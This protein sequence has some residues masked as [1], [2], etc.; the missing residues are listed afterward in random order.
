MSN[1]TEQE[2]QNAVSQFVRE[3]VKLQRS[4]LG[5]LDTNNTFS[6]VLEYAA[7]TLVFNPSSIFYLISLA[8][9]RVN[10]DV[11]LAL[12]YLDDI[13]IGINEVGRD[14]VKVTRTSLLEDAAAALL[15]AERILTES[16]AITERQFSRYEAS[17]NKFT[18]ASLTPNIR[19]STGQ[20]FPNTYQISRPPQ[21]AQSAIKTS[22]ASLSTLHTTL[23][24]EVSQLRSTFSEFLALN[25][26]L[27]SIQGTVE[28]ARTDLRT[29]KREFDAA[30]TDDAI[31]MTRDAFL[32]IE[33]G[34]AVVLNLTSISDPTEARM[35][36][37]TSNTIRARVSSSPASGTAASIALTRSAPYEVIPGTQ[38]SIQLAVDGGGTQ[39]AT[40]IPA[41][42][43]FLVGTQGETFDI[44]ASSAANLTSVGVG[45]YTVPASPNNVFDVFVDGIGYR[46]TLTSGSRTAAQVAAKIDAATRID[47]SPGTF[48]A[49]ATASDSGGSLRLQ[50]DIA[51]EN[52][53][54]I[55]DQT[56]L[57]TA[58][59][60][61]SGQ[62]ST[63]Q[64]D[65]REIRFLVDDVV[66]V[67]ATLT[68]G[69][70]T[71]AQV[72]ADIAGASASIDASAI[73][74][75]AL[76]SNLEAVKVRS[77]SYGDGS[78]IAIKPITD[79]HRE[80]MET[81]GFLED[82]T[83]RSESTSLDTLHEAI[84]ALSGI[85]AEQSRETLQE[86]DGGETILDG[87]DY[88][89]RLAS[90]TIN[91]TPAS[92]DVIRIVGGSNVGHYR[93][94]A[95]SLG[96]TFDDVTVDRPFPI[97]TG[98]ESQ[99][100][101]WELLRD[102]LIISS[103]TISSSSSLEVVGGTLIAEVGLTAG[104]VRG[105]VSGVR[106]SSSGV[107]QSFSGNDVRIGDL[108]T[109]A[110][111][112]Y[113]TTHTVTDVTDGGYQI[114]VTPE[115]SNDMSAHLFSI[116]GSAYVE[117]REFEDQIS[118]W[119][120][121]VLGPSS[122]S[123]NILELERLLNPLL[124]NKNP[125][126]A[127]VSGART[128]AQNLQSIYEDLSTILE[129]FSVSA[130]TRID[131]LLDMLLERGL[132]RAHELLLL[133]QVSE[134]FSM[135]RDSASYSGNL[136]E[137]MREMAQ[138]DVPLGRGAE[139]GHTEERLLGSYEDTDFNWDFSDADAE[140]DIPEIDDTVLEEEEDDF[141]TKVY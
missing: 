100:Q 126:A 26:P 6:E 72:A 125:S 51:G 49:V 88:K 18:E 70:R 60:F 8:A 80:A 12:E 47:G 21:K 127:L 129:D 112:T 91:A 103:D 37:T 63:G 93:I 110:G 121:N 120:S 89:L 114:E 53:I 82:Q 35:E 109:L 2:V 14:T 79:V 31:G 38:D 74:V 135:T 52:T 95:V 62:S 130:V 24:S 108:L 113:S 17:L 134:F 1:F 124:V 33:A 68:T 75:E 19:E 27:L 50:H 85:T 105:T 48:S 56:T 78:S 73:T 59:G 29:L 20:P 42:P 41:D 97:V 67:A 46:A 111:P 123:E 71:A 107:D 138:N 117:Y 36:G 94:T 13:L 16:S 66:V 4:Q 140:L 90:G 137:K 136:L 5:P 106:V 92:G 128:A 102:V 76:P 133:G 30:T 104:T 99:N 57:N 3:G 131:A 119:D 45:P 43:A 65:N 7:G 34:K 58:L 55:G 83:A 87:A 96:G 10:Q 77:T 61:T 54:T 28:K 23:L 9:N 64:A 86:G 15:E 22:V 98:T 122:F 141:L 25:L 81:L 40:I 139:M 69:T 84:N 32:R 39:T 101:S 118:Y 132:D 11:E 116:Q 44:H 115:I